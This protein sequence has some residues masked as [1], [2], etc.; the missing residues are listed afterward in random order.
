MIDFSHPQWR[1][2][3]RQLLDNPTSVVRARQWQPLLGL[4]KDNQLLLALGNHHYELTP[5]GRRYL[6]RELKLAEIATAP[7]TPEEWL[8]GQGW[9]LAEQVNERVL[10]AL[11]RKSEVSFSPNEQIDFEDKGIRLCADQLLR[12]RASEPFSL[13]FSGGTL[14]DAAPWLQALGEVALPE[15]TL[16]GLGKIL[17]GEGE[18]LRV[19]TTDSVGAFAELVLQAGTLLVWAPAPAQQALQQVIAALPPQVQWSHLTSLDPSGVDRVLTLA[20]R[21]G[22]PASWWLPTSLA[23]IM[24]AYALPLIDSRPWEPSRI[25][26]SLLAV[27]SGLVESNGGL[28][29]EVCALAPQWHAIG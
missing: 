20:Q 16:A 10:A 23:P 6:T 5:A 28:S 29:A 7:P 27:C 12:L 21:L 24:A 3:A 9:Q 14:L 11:Y 15:R 2:L 26:K 1:E 18:L 8:H 22:R 25:P 4:L 19:I 13:F 17:W